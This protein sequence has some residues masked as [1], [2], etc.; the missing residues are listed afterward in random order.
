MPWAPGQPRRLPEALAPTLQGWGKDGP[1]RCGLARATGTDEAL[2][3]SLDH[4]PGSAGQRTARR[5]CCQRP[6]MRPYRPTSHAL[7]GDPQ[8][9]QAAREARAA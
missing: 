9:Q 3:A 5:A 6:S 1:Q 7:R 4:T 2:A 8:E